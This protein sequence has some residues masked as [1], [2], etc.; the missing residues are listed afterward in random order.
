MGTLT[1][2]K[3]NRLFW[4]GRYL[5]RVYAALKES[6]AIFDADVDGR[7]ADYGRFCRQLGIPNI[8]RNTAD[9]CERFYFDL[10]NP[11]SVAS[12]LSYAYDTAVV[13]RETLSSD[14]LAYIQLAS[15]AMDK[16]RR[17]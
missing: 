7:E 17:R 4:L 3:T 10:D 2:S 11:N 13:L 9:F 15:N 8:Y 16:A 6:K 1:V 5:E 14:T 12:S